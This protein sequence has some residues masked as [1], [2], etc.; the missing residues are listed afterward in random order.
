MKLIMTPVLLKI[1]HMENNEKT[2]IKYSKK[3]K[4][5]TLNKDAWS[6]SKVWLSLPVTHT[7]NVRK[8]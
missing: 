3:I 8:I 5:H 4:L 1:Q 6:R 2:S 7:D